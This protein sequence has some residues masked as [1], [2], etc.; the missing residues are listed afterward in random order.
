MRFSFLALALAG[1]AAVTV[2]E[3]EYDRPDLADTY[4]DVSIST[5][6]GRPGYSI[7]DFNA[8]FHSSITNVIEGKCHYSFVP[9]GTKTTRRSD[10]M[11]STTK[12]NGKVD[13]SHYCIKPGSGTYSGCGYANGCVSTKC[14]NEK[15]GAA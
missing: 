1:S 6:S 3:S 4:W 13:I 2:A 11:S 12:G 8:T 14:N 10:G 15:T 9:Q 7:R 5:Q